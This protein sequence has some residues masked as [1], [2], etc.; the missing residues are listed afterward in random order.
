MVA[1]FHIIAIDFR[2]PYNGNNFC[3]NTDESDLESLAIVIKQ[4]EE[5]RNSDSNWNR[6][7]EV[8]SMPA[9]QTENKILW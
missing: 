4:K 9:I 1:H 8:D 7:I 6:L 3:N 5:I 2:T